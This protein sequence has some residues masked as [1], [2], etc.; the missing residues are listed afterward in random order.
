MI[1][2]LTLNPSIDYIM[3]VPAIGSED[4]L[5]AQYAFF[6]AGGKGINVSRVLTRFEIPNEAWGFC[7]GDTGRWLRSFLE[8]DQVPHAFTETQ[9]ATRINTILTDMSTHRQIRVS[10]SGGTVLSSEEHAL[11]DR[12][13]HLPTD[14][15]WVCLGG[16]VPP[17]LTTGC[18]RKLIEMAHNQ[19]VPAI[20]DADGEVLKAG[21]QGKPYLIK[22][23]QF[24]L[25]RLLGKAVQSTPD[26]ID[27]ARS[28][29]GQGLVQV[30]VISLAEAGALLITQEKVFHGKAP[31]VPVVSKVG[32]GDSMVAGL[33]RGIVE[34]ASFEEILRMGIA[35]GT[36]AVMAP[37]TELCRVEDYRELLPRIEI[38]SVS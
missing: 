12:F 25:E 10:A 30:V 17:G 32:A 16:S 15:Q 37:G 36:A 2:T 35:A 4:T 20:L 3:Q 31:S 22:P 14:V 28:L 7:G 6:Q 13:K 23:N 26:M 27:G 9:A 33:I 5:R 21:L 8:E 29:I 24:E 38:Q 19:G 11:I 18:M 1:I 34:K